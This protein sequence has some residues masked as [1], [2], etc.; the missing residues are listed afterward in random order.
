VSF[1][2]ILAFLLSMM[3]AVFIFQNTT[4]VE[5]RFLFWT[6]SMSRALMI[7]AVLAIGMFLS[8]LLQGYLFLRRKR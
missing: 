4:V 8:W 7:L 2:L 3:V 6:L 5:I 1:K